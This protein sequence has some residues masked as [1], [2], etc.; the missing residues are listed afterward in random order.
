M[1]YCK[2]YFPGRHE[3]IESDA[4][5]TQ[6]APSQRKAFPFLESLLSFTELDIRK[7]AVALRCI[8]DDLESLDRERVTNAMVKLGGLAEMHSFFRVLY[9]KW[10]YLHSV[11]FGNTEAA[12]SGALDELRS[13]PEELPLYQ[14][15]ILHFFELILDI[16]KAGR[17]P[18]RQVM[19]YYHFDKPDQ[20]S[21]P[22]LFPFRLLTTRFEPADGDACAPVLYANTVADMISFS[23]QTCVERSITV[24]RCKN[25]GRYF[26]QTGRISAE[27]CDRT[28]LDGQ[29]SC[30]AMGA[31][32]QW[33]LK[34]AD[35]P[36]FKVYRREYKRRFA[37]I[38]AGRISDSE[39]YAWSEQARE[40]KKRCDEGSITAEDF[41]RWLKES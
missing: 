35:D 4:F 41:Q 36:V 40:Q 34:Q 31:F 28:P 25:C 15:H 29:S 22:E 13:L 10:F 6:G 24:R 19:R 14:K 30:R 1:W 5:G 16:D 17:E 23:L 26:A 33:T 9:T 27:Y 7:V 38:K 8:S 21:D 18:S 11:G 3:V 39:F 32:Q 20:P 2:M 12:V 37:W